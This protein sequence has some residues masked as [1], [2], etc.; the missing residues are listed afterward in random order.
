MSVKRS[1]RR[2]LI[3]AQLVRQD[4]LVNWSIDHGDNPEL[5]TCSGH[6]V[7]SKENAAND[8]FPYIWLKACGMKALGNSTSNSEAGLN[9]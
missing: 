9:A 5:E 1:L 7:V 3:T 2:F 6:T 4:G 8:N